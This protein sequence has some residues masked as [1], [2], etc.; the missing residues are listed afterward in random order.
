MAV[1]RREFLFD[2]EK[3]K[4]RIRHILTMDSHPG[5]ISLGFA[6]GVFISFTPFFGF[7]SLMAIVAA[8]VFRL[9][10][11][12]CVTGSWVNTPLTV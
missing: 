10:K 2:K 6:V 12:T 8:F 3:W 1:D 5:H 7:H 4:K 9:N 11:L